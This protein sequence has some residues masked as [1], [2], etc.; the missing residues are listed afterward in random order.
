V[1]GGATVSRI[2]TLATRADEPGAAQQ[3]LMAFVR[4]N[5][6]CVRSGFAPGVCGS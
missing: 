2:V 6:P 1:T 3:R 5:S 4:A